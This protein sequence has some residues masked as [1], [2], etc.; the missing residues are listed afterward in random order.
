MATTVGGPTPSKRFAPRIMLVVSMLALPIFGVSRVGAAP[1]HTRATVSNDVEQQMAGSTGGDM[2]TV[3]VKFRQQADVHRQ[4]SG[5]RQARQKSLIDEMHTVADSTQAPMRSLLTSRERDGRVAKF[6]PLWVVN[7]VSVTAT[8]DVIDELSRRP[9]VESISSDIADVVPTTLPPVPATASADAVVIDAPALWNLGFYGQGVVVADLDS[10]VDASHPD[11]AS[12]YRGGTNSWF[13]PYGQ[14]TTPTDMSGHGTATTGIIVG[15]DTSGPTIGVAP[16]A[17]WIAAKIFNDAGTATTTAI[18]QAMQWVLDPDGNP[19][20]A[21]APQVVNNSWAYGNPGCNLQFQPDL[22]AMR[23]AGIIPV[24]AAG[25]FGPTAGTSVSPANYPEALAV[26]S[27]DNTD[28]IDPITSEGP[29]ACGEPS[30]TYPDVVAPGFDIYTTDLHGFYQW[31]SGTSFAAPHVTGA[32]ALL[33]SAQPTAAAGV[34]AALETSAVDL[35][36]VGA[37]NVYGHGRI[38]VSAALQVLQAPPTTTTTTST[39]ST[40]TTTAPTTTS[41][42]TTTT[43][44]T[45]TA[46]TTTSSTT[47]TTMVP[48]APPTA[49]G[50]V[51]SPSASNGSSNVAISATVVAGATGTVSGAEYFVDTVGATG[52]GQVMTGTFGASSVAVTATMSSATIGSLSNG[53]HSIAVRGRDSAGVW[54]PLVTSNL[55]V[56]RLGPTFTAVS[57]TPSTATAGGTTMVTATISGASDG[58]GT[59]VSGGEYWV[60]S[61]APPTG[62]GTAF[63]GLA[64]VLSVSSPA[65]GSYTVSVRLRDVLAN[66]GTAHSATLTVNSATSGFSD[67]FES[68]VLPG[69]WSSVSTSNTTRLAVTTTAALAGTFGLRAQGD[70]TNFVQY[71]VSPAAPLCDARF[72]FRPNG[73]TSS[74]QVIFTGATSSNFSST[75]FRVRYRLSGTTPQVQVQLG[76]STSNTSWVNLTGGSANNAIEVVWQAAKNSTSTRGVVKLMVNGIVAQS[77]GTSSTA[78][79]GAIRLGSVSNGSSSIAE[80]FDA[81]AS[82]YAAPAAQLLSQQLVAT[83][84][85]TVVAPML[86]PA[87]RRH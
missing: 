36:A 73:N 30:T 67:G 83:R 7:G 34:E 10:G 82:G 3:I 62:S 69:A 79:V 17:K 37:D 39:T 70:N 54:G 60:G 33:L 42:T 28:S 32:I 81:Y 35:G 43:T 64:P 14:H 26:G 75:V 57:I 13:D 63:T 76:T 71:N 5:N 52:T 22:Q 24:F 2:L 58:S 48:V 21:D 86:W 84:V 16:G 87:S 80:Y 27:T 31:G 29:S 19:A 18:H 47:T 55:L 6:Q 46:P 74:A 51:V 49:S 56:D 23:A 72:L 78:S 1:K 38:N 44:T 41:S 61:T 12:S 77:L 85:R 66:W 25:N 15:G 20:T 8:P 11:L 50:L 59:G 4:R 9:E 68:G 53:N 45:T 40:T 65:A